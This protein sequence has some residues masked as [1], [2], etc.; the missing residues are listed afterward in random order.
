[1][2]ST[3][4]TCVTLLYRKCSMVKFLLLS[5]VPIILLLTFFLFTVNLN[6]QNV[7]KR[8]K[9]CGSPLSE[10]PYKGAHPKQEASVTRTETSSSPQKRQISSNSTTGKTR[11]L[12][13]TAATDKA[14][15]EATQANSEIS[16]IQRVD[17]GLSVCWA[18]YNLG[19]NSPEQWGG[20]YAWGETDPKEDFVHYKYVRN[21]STYVN[22]GTN[23]SG[24][25]YD[26]ARVNWGGDWRLPTE[27]EAN[28][29]VERCHW[30]PTTYKGVTGFK[31]TG[32]NGNAIFMP[33]AGFYRAYGTGVA[34]KTE[35]WDNHGY[36]MTGKTYNATSDSSVSINMWNG[37][38]YDVR[39][40]YDREVGKSV[41]A[42][43]K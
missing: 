22:I 21:N 35:K 10:C 17:L 12:T 36:Y 18:G 4:L 11:R 20:F 14:Q 1:M 33:F 19:A 26:A 38:F 13:T 8:C 27:G 3:L 25:K 37:K 41:R 30:Q 7:V 2:K 9:T 31:I 39:S 34:A 5:G 28:E 24:T 29:L 16:T 6:A 15:A 23:I 32:P 42:V 40:N 43:C